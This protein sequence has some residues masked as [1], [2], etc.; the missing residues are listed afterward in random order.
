MSAR[1]TAGLIA[2]I[3]FFGIV[4]A[5][6]CVVAWIYGYRAGQVAIRTE[7]C[8]TRVGQYLLPQDCP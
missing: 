2:E 4:A 5:T 8:N 1:D 6:L 3:L 7:V